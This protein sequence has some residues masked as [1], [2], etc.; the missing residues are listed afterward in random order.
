MTRKMF[1]AALVLSVMVGRLSSQEHAGQYARAD[2]E[3]GLRLFGE[4]CVT[5]HGING[6]GVAGINLRSGQFRN[7]PSDR[8]LARIITRGITDTAMPPGEYSTSELAGLVA[9]LRTMGDVDPSTVTLGDSREG[10][11]VFET[12]GQCATC[13]R[14]K[15]FGPRI[16]PDL[17]EVGA[18]RTAGALERTLVDP[19]GSMLPI[20]RPVRAV[21]RE[22]I[23]FSGRRLNEDTYTVQLIDEQGRLVSLEKADL[24]DYT[25][26]EVSPMPSYEGRLSEGEL[27][28]LLAYL[29]SLKGLE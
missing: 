20:N 19:T 8:E 18:T 27:A 29:L 6:D 17:S 22:G 10:R 2:I 21:T 4:Y 16:A 24:S 23:T 1:W 12:K 25:I 5:C 15:G 7:A 13:H 26:S 14:V 11:I 28:D 3:Y 9:Y